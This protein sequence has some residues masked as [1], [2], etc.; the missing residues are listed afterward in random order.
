MTPLRHI[1]NVPFLNLEIFFLLGCRP[2]AFC[3]ASGARI[4]NILVVELDRVPLAAIL[5]IRIRGQRIFG[6]LNAVYQTTFFPEVGNAFRLPLPL[7]G[8][9]GYLL[10][11][12][13]IWP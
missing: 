13:L 5:T 2:N 10:L 12:S 3:A 8:V 1:V 9:L 11:H 6:N 7:D 4:R